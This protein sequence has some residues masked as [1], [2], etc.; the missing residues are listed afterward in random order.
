MTCFALTIAY[1][2][3][4]Y[5]G[6]QIQEVSKAPLTIQGE[7]EKILTK[8]TGTLVRVHGAGRTDSGV[9]AEGQV[10]HIHIND[11]TEH[12]KK[13][14]KTPLEWQRIFNTQLPSD[15]SVLAVQRVADNFHSRFNA[16]S[17]TY[18]YTFWTEPHY[19]PPRAHPFVWACGKL[20]LEAMKM[21]LPYLQ[22]QHD[23]CCLQNVGTPIENTVRTVLAIDLQQ[24]SPWLPHAIGQSALCLTVT[25]DGFLK[26]MVRNMAG[27]LC[28][29]GRHKFIPQNIPTLFQNAQRKLA[30]PTAPA[31][32]L[33]LVRVHYETI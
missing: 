16:V 8:V 27:L 30:P 13:K 11:N 12:T 24:G 4:R 14:A 33:S 17:K 29:V 9:H 6:W 15:I 28:A 23:F 19:I 3:T 20:D 26:Q 2:G 25:A 10:A 21:A 31:C 22:G 5:A 1:V 18:A 32:G 7:L